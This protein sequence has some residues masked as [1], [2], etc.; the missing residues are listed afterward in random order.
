VDTYRGPPVTKGPLAFRGIGTVNAPIAKVV[1]VLA[2][3]ER[4]PE[5]TARLREDEIIERSG[6]YDF[7]VW[8]HFKSPP[9]VKDRDFVLHAKGEMA[10]DGKTF[11]IT[12]KSVT[13][14]D[15]PD[16]KCCVR[17][18]VLST[19]FRLR[20]LDDRHTLVDTETLMDA[21]GKLPPSAVNGVQKDWPRDTIV[22]LRK[23]VAKPEGAPPS[24]R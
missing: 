18:E 6:P 24:A 5:W 9:F 13:R 7:V 2:T 21:K 22:G 1:R 23:Q 14:P 16:R 17:G 20:A 19:V 10:A 15:Q 3:P 4:F 11:T 12:Y 8:Q